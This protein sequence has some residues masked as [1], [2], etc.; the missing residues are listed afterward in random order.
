[1]DRGREVYREHCALC[2]QLEN[3]G[4]NVGP[5]LLAETDRDPESLLVAILDPNRTVRP[6]YAQYSLITMDG[7]VLV[8]I[9]A[10]ETGNSLTLID[11][12]GVEHKFLRSDVDELISTGQSLMPKD[13]EQL[14]SSDQDLL[15]LIAYLRA[16][17]ADPASKRPRPGTTDSTDQP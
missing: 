10:A 3:V 12:Q 7:R 11:A 16:V 15:D 1:M 5:D 4:T 6:R 9:V 14:F 13:V 2:H 17:E 8:G